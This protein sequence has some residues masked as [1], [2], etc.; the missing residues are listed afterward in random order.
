MSNNLIIMSKV[1]SIISLYTEGV[2]ENIKKYLEYSIIVYTFVI[3]N[4]GIT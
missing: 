2:S 1:R 4:K 3:L